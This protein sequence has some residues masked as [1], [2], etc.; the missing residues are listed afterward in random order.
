M[1]LN[2]TKKIHGTASYVHYFSLPQSFVGVLGDTLIFGVVLEKD[3]IPKV[4]GELSI[5]KLIG[6]FLLKN[7]SKILQIIY[8][9]I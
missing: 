9:Y 5:K 3:L 2:I 4:F 6:M 7:L 8:L 1:T